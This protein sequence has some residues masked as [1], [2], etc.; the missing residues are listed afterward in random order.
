MMSN[1]NIGYF[2]IMGI[3]TLHVLAGFGYLAY[4]LSPNK[5]KAKR[6]EG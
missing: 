2:I 3:I 4:K 1:S 5:K 6:P